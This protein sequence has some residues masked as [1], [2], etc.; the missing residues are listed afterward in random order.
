MRLEVQIAYLK[1]QIRS[2]WLYQITGGPQALYRGPT[3]DIGS[4]LNAGSFA[5]YKGNQEDAPV[6]K[7]LMALVNSELKPDELPIP[8]DI[9]LG[10]FRK[11]FINWQFEHSGYSWL[12]AALAAGHGDIETTKRYLHNIRNK[13]HS[14]KETTRVTEALW[15]IVTDMDIVNAGT[16]LGTLVAAKVEG[17]ATKEQII[18]W[19]RGKDRTR[20]NTGCI[21]PKNPPKNIMPNHLDGQNCVPQRCTFCRENAV[22]FPDSIAPFSQR[23]VEL[24]YMR[25]TISLESWEDSDFG[26]EVKEIEDA[27]CLWPNTEVEASIAYWEKKMESPCNSLSILEGANV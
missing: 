22:L 14:Q 6:C 21:S 17:R 4:L 10:S 27:L 9:T 15:S 26:E 25:K 19:L 23:L 1:R 18:R 5:I 7:Y 13:F 20:L 3:G 8:A 24:R 16:E 12:S 2:P 11:H